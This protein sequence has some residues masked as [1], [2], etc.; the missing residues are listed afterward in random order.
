MNSDP[1]RRIRG[2]TIAHLI[3]S[4]GPGGAERMV[5]QLASELQTAGC[6]CVV[7]LPADG[8]GWLAD[9][10]AGTSVTIEP[11]RL[12]RPVSA[13][14]ARR[15]AASFRRHGVAVAHSHEFTMAIYSA[16][17]A[18]HA[19]VGHLIT[20]HGG[21]YYAGRLRR[22]LALRVAFGFSHRVVAV[23]KTVAHRLSHDLWLPL[24]RIETIPNGVR[25]AP[26]ARSTLRDELRLSR[27]DR[28]MLAVGNLY[29]VKGHVHLLEAIAQLRD[30]HP[31]LHAAIAGRGELAGMLAA[32]ARSLGVADRVHLLG[33]R[34]DVT[35]LLAAADLFVLPSLSEGLPLALLEAMFAGCPI[36][37]SDVGEIRVALRNG[38]AGILVPPGDAAELAAAIDRLLRNSDLA[39]QLGARAARRAGTQYDL[40]RMMERYAAI[41]SELFRPGPP[42]PRD[43]QPLVRGVL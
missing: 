36:I 1:L 29:R 39:R 41:Y 20:M 9:E 31:H 32:R 38:E 30:D 16:W 42:L 19:G 35:N 21:R 3:E 24:S 6:R 17:A 7:F 25:F 5:A 15:L 37:A 28:L 4:D 23:S 34:R 2:A 11:F 43:R 8:E 12:E 13:A 33:L 22:R 18:R 10:L 14:S 40:S 26:V 27:T